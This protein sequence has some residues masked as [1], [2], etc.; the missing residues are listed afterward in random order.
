M[1][2]IAISAALCSAFAGADLPMAAAGEAIV[3]AGVFGY[4]IEITREV[5]G[6]PVE[7]KSSGGP[8]AILSLINRSA[9]PAS[10]RADCQRTCALVISRLPRYDTSRVSLG[11]HAATSK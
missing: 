5:N 4:R 10:C 1:K 7:I 11:S 6:L 3:L 8:A 2:A 9:T